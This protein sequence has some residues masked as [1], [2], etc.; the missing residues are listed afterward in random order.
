MNNSSNAFW[1]VVI[2]YG[3]ITA[4]ISMILKLILY[5]ADV[6]FYSWL[7]LIPILV[8]LGGQI[9]SAKV[10]RDIYNEGVSSFAQIFGITILVGLLIS[11]LTSGFSLA[12][13]E[14]DSSYL[15][16]AVRNLKEMLEQAYE[17][18][19]LS[20]E[21]YQESLTQIGTMMK[22]LPIA[23]GLM[24]RYTIANIVFSLL[25]ALFI[26]KEKLD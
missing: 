5:I 1:K 18:G 15:T 2:Y 3:L 4:L 17:M 23:I 24:V 13:Y 14:L 22:P 21:R 20:R 7:H 16:V 9:W 19:N 12:L 26:K 8:L 25:I 11:L 6:R 10:F